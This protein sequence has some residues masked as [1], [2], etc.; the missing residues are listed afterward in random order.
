[1][2][3]KMSFK[4]IAIGL[5]LLLLT[6][7]IPNISTVNAADNTTFSQSSYTLL[8]GYKQNLEILNKSQ[9][10][11]YEL[12]VEDPTIAHAIDESTIVGQKAG[13]TSIVLVEDGVDRATASLVVENSEMPFSLNFSTL[14]IDLMEVK[15]LDLTTN[16]SNAQD[17]LYV[18]TEND[19]VCQVLDEKGVILG[20]NAGSTNLY[21]KN[22]LNE[23]IITVPVVV[24]T[25]LADTSV[26][27]IVGI[28]KLSSGLASTGRMPV[29]TSPHDE[30]NN[31]YVTSSNPSV[32]EILNPYD[33]SFISK[34]A[35][36]STLTAIHTSGATFESQVTV[37]GPTQ[38]VVE[39]NVSIETGSTKQLNVLTYPS[40]NKS[41]LKYKSSDTALFTVSSGGQISTLS[42]TGFGTLLIYDEPT[43]SCKSVTVAVSAPIPYEPPTPGDNGS[44]PDT[45]I[46]PSFKISNSLN[47]SGQLEIILGNS[48]TISS[49]VINKGTHAVDEAL[50]VVSGTDMISLSGKVVTAKKAGVA[51]VK[52]YDKNGK[53]EPLYVYILCKKATI[54]NVTGGNLTQIVDKTTQSGISN[55]NATK[56]NLNATYQINLTAEGVA[57][58]G[59][60][61]FDTYYYLQ[62][63]KKY[64]SYL[65]KGK[66]KA[67]YPGDTQILV[68]TTD[69]KKLLHKI[70]INIPYDK[71][72]FTEAATVFG[73]PKNRQIIIKLN[74]PVNISTINSTSVFVQKDGTGNGENL[75]CILGAD[76]NQL[77]ITLNS[78]DIKELQRVYIYVK[79]IKDTS[80]RTISRPTMIPIEF[81]K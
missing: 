11:T 44:G 61:L 7:L 41:R 60:D 40:A 65:G 35:G 22:I 43:G 32:C 34:A 58:T 76:R 42:K 15:S 31:L 16:P 12:R 33:G 1:M 17:Y 19:M 38:I 74:A 45:T 28:Q 50:Q 4:A 18:E 8:K 52:I 80:G 51:R 5:C 47:S 26:T 81:S 14:T 73:I 53:A 30:M 68:Y 56:V 71:E 27:K 24:Q 79:D 6:S 25:D 59:G 2:S 21:I 39:D 13:S 64:L 57:N 29:A 3:K 37:I 9:G 63:D 70:N 48:A 20:I 23:E 62:F 54:D 72:Y 75:K 49:T 77:K 78:D 36:T 69:K 55:A 66:I 46:N 10:S 67:I